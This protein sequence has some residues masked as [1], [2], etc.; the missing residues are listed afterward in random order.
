VTTSFKIILALSLPL[1][2]FACYYPLRKEPTVATLGIGSPGPAVKGTNQDGV[3][4]DF[5]EVYAKGPTVVFFYP[6]ADTPG[7]TAQA[8]SLRDAFSDL[9]K[10]GVQVL[11]V[12]LDGQKAQQ[13]FRDKYKLPF[14]LIADPEGTLLQAFGV[15][16]ML[17][18]MLPLASRQCFLFRE[19]KLVWHDASAS[20]ATQ[21]AD[22][23]AALTS[24]SR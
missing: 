4:V 24:S 17:K 2:A 15:G 20:T 9:T 14:D 7:C 12:S 8:C 22:I 5:K 11:G 18:G 23:T 3:V 1:L 10:Q 16:K 21:A 6:K 19:G 13:A